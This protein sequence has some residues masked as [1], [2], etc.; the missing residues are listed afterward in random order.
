MAEEKGSI[1]IQSNKTQ[2]PITE[3]L[4]SM[5]DSRSRIEFLDTIDN[6]G[7]LKVLI[8][9]SRKKAK[10]LPR[11]SKGRIVVDIENLHILENMD[12]FRPRALYYQEHGCYTHLFYNP[13]P[14]SEYRMFW[15]EERRRCIEGYVRESDGEWIPGYFYF[16]LNY[17][18]IDLVSAIDSANDTKDGLAFS[19]VVG[20]I[21]SERKENFPDVWD[22]DYIYFHYI[23][24]AEED[25][26]HGAVLK[27]RGRGYS[28]KGSSMLARNYFIVKKSKSY[29]LASEQEYLVKDGLLTKA[30]GNINFVDNNTPWTQPRDYKDTEIHKRASYKD[31]ENKTEKGFLSEVIGVTCK[32]NPQ[33]AHPYS[34]HIVTPYGEMLWRDVNIGTKLFDRNG[35]IT[36]VTEV[37]EFGEQDVYRIYFNDG[38]YI[39]SSINHEWE[40]LRFNTKSIKNKSYHN[41]Q[42]FKLETKDII[43]YLSSGSNKANKLKIAVPSEVEFPKIDVPMDAYTL[44]LMLGDGSIGKSTNNQ[45]VI[46]MKHSDINAISEFIP[47]KVRNEAWGG[48]IRNVIFIDN[49]RDIYKSLG[50]FNSRAGDKFIPNIYKYNTKEVRLGII[51]GLLDTDGSVTRDFGV[52]EYSTKS[53]Q[54]AKDF[55]WIVRSLGLN[56]SIK[57]RTIN[58]TIYYRCYIYCD[59]NETRLF[60]LP[61]KKEI[62]KKKKDNAFAQNKVK[63]IHIDRIEKRSSELIKCVTVDS[64]DTMYLVGDFVPT[65]NSRGKRGKLLLFEEAGKFPGLT[66]AW[67]IARKSVE[68]GRYVFGFMCSYGTGG[69][70][71]SDFEALEQFF[72]SP[73]G[74]NIKYMNNIFDKNPGQG[75]CAL[76]IPEYLNRQ[77]CYDKNGN[78]NVIKALLEVFIQRQTI[79]NNTSDPQALIQ[80]K[81]ETC[82]TPQEA[83]LRIEGSLFPV[84]DLKEYLS[85]ISPSMDKFTASHYTGSLVYDINGEIE[86]R[87]SNVIPIR[88]YPAKDLNKEGCVEIFEMPSKVLSDRYIVSVDTYDDDDVTWSNSLGSVFVFD[89]W[90]RSFVAEYTGRPNT[91]N[92]FYEITY[93]IARYYN[94]KIMYENNKKGLFAYFNNVKNAVWMLADT[95][96]YL[97]DKSN[98]RVSLTSNTSKGVCATAAINAHARRMIRDW[99]MEEIKEPTGELDVDGNNVY[100]IYLRL[101]KI[102]SI[103]LLK[104][105]IAWTSDGNFDRISSLGM[106]MLYDAELSQYEYTGDRSKIVKRG[107]DPF[108]DRMFKMNNNAI[109]VFSYN[110]Q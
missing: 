105:A 101:Q 43:K 32:D 97:R 30:W 77:G 41:I 25:G 47:Y 2:S 92:E 89:R 46:T 109:N 69:T 45:S 54:L 40:C 60:N 55:I 22:G 98:I 110:K 35:T 104:E 16:Y 86:F 23:E 17:T 67:A 51:N 21:R 42:K 58:G 44:G 82:I 66:T 95:P 62:I 81:A 48:D 33:K 13:A 3:E 103:G 20:G 34:Q 50:L 106:A 26:K 108:F 64:V 36:T 9:P 96:E 15:D 78:S 79:R 90:S 102:R 10:D 56:G 76:F 74:Y 87:N 6:I 68:Q 14:N 71:S 24:Q 61:R 65:F 31:V 19:A 59:R 99:M 8:N 18:P 4:L 72:Y 85:S 37:H 93:R 11:D 73:A 5:L 39:D 28:F 83:V 94:A 63:Y 38:R 12:Y 107:D 100:R 27:T 57:E 7:L 75:I 91:A 52:I 70:I 88:D 29:A 84:L 49:G 1:L 53:S 80:E